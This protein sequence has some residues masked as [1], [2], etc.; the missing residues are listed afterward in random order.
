MN[1]L[2]DMFRIPLNPWIS[3]NY[4]STRHIAKL[5]TPD[6]AKPLST[7]SITSP[8]FRSEKILADVHFVV[9]L[10]SALSIFRADVLCLPSTSPNATRVKSNKLAGDLG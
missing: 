7:F 1:H 6:C 3:F 2:T 4:H 5:C 10:H 8:D 9:P